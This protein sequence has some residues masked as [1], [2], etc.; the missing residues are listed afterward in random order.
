MRH[1][2]VVLSDVTLEF[3]R[4]HTLRILRYFH[5]SMGGTNHRWFESP[6]L[7]LIGLG[8]KRS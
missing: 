1:L 2:V 8:S 3:R 5:I 7:R 4:G 6:N